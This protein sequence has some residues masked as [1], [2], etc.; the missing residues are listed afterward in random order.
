MAPLQLIDFHSDI[1][2]Y[3]RLEAEPWPDDVD[4]GIALSFELEA[5]HDE[6]RNAQQLTLTIGYND[7][8]RI[9]DEAAPYIAHRG[10]ISITGWLRWID[11]EI[12]ARDNARELLFTNGF[13]MLYSVARVRV[14]DLTEGA[15]TERL[16]LPSVNFLPMVRDWLSQ[17]EVES[18]DESSEDEPELAQSE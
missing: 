8:D 1:L 7:E 2:A 16:L 13:S 4:E 10:R 14:A 12:A 9:P 17:S 11:E 5:R 6:D 15:S 3:K 18:E